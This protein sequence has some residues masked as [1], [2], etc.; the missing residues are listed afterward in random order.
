MV[1]VAILAPLARPG[2]VL[3]YDMNFVPRQPLRW[4]LVA[5]DASLPRAVPLDAVVGALSLVAPGW[6]LQRLFLAGLVYLAAWGAARAVPTGR[7][8]IRLIAAV[9]YAWTPFLAERLLIGQ[10]GL[11]LAYAALPWLLAALIDLRE[12]RAGALP[13]LALAAGAGALTPTGALVMAAMIVALVPGRSPAGRVRQWLAVGL[14]ALINLPWL[15]AAVA[16]QAGGRSDPAG[17]AVFAIRAENW[18]GAAVS[19]LGTGGLWNADTTPASRSS[20]LVP[21]A[22]F[23]ILS[24]AAVGAPSLRRR[25]PAGLAVRLAAV[26]AAG[27]ALAL[28]VA[29]PGGAAALRFLVTHVPGAGLLRDGQKLLMPYALLL[30]LAA[31]VGVDRITARWRP[32]PAAI[33]VIGALLLPVAA[34]PDLAYGGAGALRPVSYPADWAAVADRLA[35]EP[36][37]VLSL[38]LAGYRRYPW[39][40]GRVVLDPALR[41]FDS[42]VLVDD[43]LRVSG[44]TVAGEDRRLSAVRAR[45]GAGGS[46][47]GTDVRWVLAQSPVPADQLVGL[48]LVYAGPDL[49]LYRNPD[50]VPPPAGAS[51]RRALVVVADALLAALVLAA[52][53]ALIAV[54]RRQSNRSA[55]AAG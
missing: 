26:A 18:A 36:G 23:L 55:A 6:L 43:R 54:R 52:A 41:Y 37:P 8:G 38:P 9:G 46:L 30:V 27:L 11:L 16:S 50:A 10:W 19:A 1:T 24:A 31:A 22:T 34:M 13:R 20:T 25:L 49:A 12:C 42:P 3:S 51:W 53:G 15:A 14:A 21:L 44:V 2:Y 29:V 5:P 7:L 48:E 39:N 33:A 32:E 17:V 28:L 45:L 4:D 35:A 47:G 40:H